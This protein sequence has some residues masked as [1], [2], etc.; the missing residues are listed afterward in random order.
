MGYTYGDIRTKFIS[1]MNRRDMTTT[2]A[3]GFLQD[4][5]T[6]TQRIL[7]V[8]AMEKSIIV[9]VDSAYT[10][11][12]GVS[13]PTDFLQMR[14]VTYNDQ[15]ELQKAD[16]STVIPLAT[17]NTG[18]PQL[19]CRRGGLWVLGPTPEGPTT[20]PNTLVTTYNKVRVDYY[21][22]FPAMINTTDET[23]LT[24]IASDVMVFGALSYACDHYADKRGDKFEARYLQ[25][26]GDLENM[27][28]EDETAGSASVRPAY[29]FAD[30]LE[31]TD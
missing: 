13:I 31:G 17:F 15:Y 5:I 8:P 6:R 21:A 11:A 18:E 25:I 9:Q 19:F 12:G 2:D 10:T 27:G 26:V 20:D 3:D 22:E 1:R 16:V 29:Q 23:W 7:R 30:D 14:Q 4:A 28:D 24:D